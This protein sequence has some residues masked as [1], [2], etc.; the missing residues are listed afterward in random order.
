VRWVETGCNFDLTLFVTTE[1][2]RADSRF[3]NDSSSGGGLIVEAEST[4]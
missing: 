3:P 1:V 2:Q 4:K